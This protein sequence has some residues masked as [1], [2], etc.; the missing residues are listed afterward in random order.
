MT[1]I[2]FGDLV[3]SKLLKSTNLFHSFAMFSAISYIILY[4][5]RGWM[6]E[7]WYRH[8][9]NRSI[10]QIK[11][12]CLWENVEGSISHHVRQNDIW[13]VEY[14]VSMAVALHF[15]EP[16]WRPRVFAVSISLFNCHRF[17]ILQRTNWL[18]KLYLYRP[19]ELHVVVHI[20]YFS[21]AGAHIND[22]RISA[23]TVRGELAGT[24][25]DGL[26]F[27]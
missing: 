8:R 20:V 2:G 11:F 9:Q 24:S 6:G 10:K 23:A 16:D 19:T 7:F 4:Y 26:F 1:T 18:L 21:W 17:E 3:P 25:G 13:L 22:H 5:I 12:T 15:S 27:F 14:S